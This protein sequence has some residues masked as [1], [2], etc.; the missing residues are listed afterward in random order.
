MKK[1]ILS[2]LLITGT[3]LTIQ[4]QGQFGLKG[5]LNY[6]ANGEY[7]A[8]SENAIE[9]PDRNI[10][11]H[12]GIFTQIGSSVYVR[13]EFI[14]TRTKADYDSNDFNVTKLDLPILLG[15]TIF[16]PV[17]I[18]AGP[19]FQ[20]ILETEF[21]G[22]KIDDIENNFTV[23][24]HVGVGVTLGKIGVDIRYERGFSDNEATFINTNLTALGTSRID[25]RPEQVIMSVSLNLL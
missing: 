18:F 19:G 14:Y 9:N 1:I 12:L 2:V 11:Y 21:D 25:T 10:G 22:I 4:A 17:N 5:G 16:G 6:G 8:S 13:P 7:I 23:G 20:Y 15:A 3:I 24:L